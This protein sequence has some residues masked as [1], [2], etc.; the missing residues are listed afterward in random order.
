MAPFPLHHSRKNGAGHVKQAFHID[1]HHSIP[2]VDI[3]RLN[4]VKT[5]GIAGVVYQHVHHP[6]PAFERGDGLFSGTTIANVEGKH[7]DIRCVSK[8]RPDRLQPVFSSAAQDKVEIVA[9][10]DARRRLADPGRCS[11]DKGC[12]FIHPLLKEQ[13]YRNRVHGNPLKGFAKGIGAV[14]KHIH[15]APCVADFG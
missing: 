10:E 1:V 9:G 8:L 6:P 2:V 7:V 3:T 11:G 13:V 12:S 14:A 5:V 4:E 15:Y